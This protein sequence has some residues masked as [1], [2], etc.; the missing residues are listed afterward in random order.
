MILYTLLSRIS[1]GL[2]L[3]CFAPLVLARLSEMMHCCRSQPSSVQPR[4]REYFGARPNWLQVPCVTFGLQVA[5]AEGPVGHDLEMYK[6]Q[7]R[8]LVKRLVDG[9]GPA[10]MSVESGSYVFKYVLLQQHDCLVVSIMLFAT[11]C[12]TRSGMI[13]A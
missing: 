11:C 5:S 6:Q 10:R 7:A 2:P 4:V 13:C 9:K 3:V 12:N 1:D 8:E